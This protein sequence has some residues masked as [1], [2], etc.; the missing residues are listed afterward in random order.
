MWTILTFNFIGA[1]GLAKLRPDV[2]R[3]EFKTV[4]SNHTRSRL[5]RGETALELSEQPVLIHERLKVYVTLFY[6]TARKIWVIVSSLSPWRQ[7]LRKWNVALLPDYRSSNDNDL[8]QS[9]KLFNEFDNRWRYRAFLWRTRLFCNSYVPSFTH[10]Q[11]K[12]LSRR[13]SVTDRVLRAQLETWRQMVHDTEPVAKT[14]KSKSASCVLDP[15]KLKPGQ[16][17]DLAS[18]F[19]I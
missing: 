5:L 12:A 17:G 16:N 8:S 15:E 10:D 9:H 4:T 13:C 11:A 7:K 14:F 2:K 6:D 19:N 1:S 18:R 3:K